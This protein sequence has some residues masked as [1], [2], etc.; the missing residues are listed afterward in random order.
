MGFKDALKLMSDVEVYKIGLHME[1]TKSVSCD[2]ELHLIR[3]PASIGHY[4]SFF[5]F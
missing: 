3:K 2:H 5:A 1:C 4:F